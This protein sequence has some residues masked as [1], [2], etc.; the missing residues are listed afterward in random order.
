MQLRLRLGFGICYFFNNATQLRTLQ[1]LGR[2]SFRSSVNMLQ[3]VALFLAWA[4]NQGLALI[5]KR[6]NIDIR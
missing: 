6:Q 2:R 3:E 5:G 1:L 4:K